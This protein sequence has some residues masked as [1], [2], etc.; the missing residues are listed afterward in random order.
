LAIVNVIKK[1]LRYSLRL[2]SIGIVAILLFYLIFRVYYIVAPTVSMWWNGLGALEK[3]TLYAIIT[4]VVAV[5]SASLIWLLYSRLEH[6]RGVRDP[7][8]RILM[9]FQGTICKL[10]LDMDRRHI[11]LPNEL[12]KIFESNCMML[13]YNPDEGG[14]PRFG[15]RAGSVARVFVDKIPSYVITIKHSK[16]SVSFAEDQRKAELPIVRKVIGEI[17]RK[18]HGSFS[19]TLSI[20]GYGITGLTC[21]KHFPT[22]R[23]DILLRVVVA[24]RERAG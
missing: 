14:V 4:I 22:P 5:L 13:A 10:G 12:N 21:G 24:D 23:S 19:A 15:R 18:H 20:L 3:L 2:L 7:Q 11:D 6:E 16:Q 9:I 17:E 1:E 8:R